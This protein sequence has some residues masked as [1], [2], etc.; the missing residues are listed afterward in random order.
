M[1]NIFKVVVDDFFDRLQNYIQRD[2]HHYRS[3]TS[4]GKYLEWHLIYYS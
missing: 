4:K 3:Q 2:P 1:L